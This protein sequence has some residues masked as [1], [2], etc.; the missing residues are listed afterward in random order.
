[1]SGRKL[2][3]DPVSGRRGASPPDADKYRK[4][5]PNAVWVHNPYTGHQR[6]L[7]DVQSDPK[8]L[9]II[10]RLEKP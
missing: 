6:D 4:H 5:H 1:M 10:E 8:G 3:Y 2:K 7:R 9:L